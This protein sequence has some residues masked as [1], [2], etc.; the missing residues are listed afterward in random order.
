MLN[1]THGE[2]TLMT[3]IH[4]HVRASNFRC[5][6]LSWSDY[7]LPF[8]CSLE[9][10][11]LYSLRF[12]SFAVDILVDSAVKTLSAVFF[13]IV[14]FVLAAYSNP[15]PWLVFVC[16]KF[17]TINCLAKLIIGNLTN[18]LISFFLKKEI[19][20]WITMDTI[21]PRTGLPLITRIHFS[22]TCSHCYCFA[23]DLE[24]IS[25]FV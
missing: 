22:S 23:L 11:S 10:N 24:N 20:T 21:L 5:D 15:T 19:D 14:S 25:I 9:R 3:S 2:D 8:L 18:S 7:C 1:H 16:G 12:L 17:I 6:S 13:L 4:L